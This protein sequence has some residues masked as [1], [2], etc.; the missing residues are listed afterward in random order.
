MPTAEATSAAETGPLSSA[1]NESDA[2]HLL[3]GLS[4]AQHRAVT[5]ETT[6][7][8]ILAGPGSGKTRVLTRRITWRALTGAEDPRRTL[9]LTFTRKAAG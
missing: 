6:P 2:D 1:V 7:L 5:A 8:A 3:V 9:A 4:E